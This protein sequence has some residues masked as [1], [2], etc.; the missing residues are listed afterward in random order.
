MPSQAKAF[1]SQGLS[2]QVA[3]DKESSCF[4]CLVC[5]GF[6]SHSRGVFAFQFTW[7]RLI[8][9]VKRTVS[10]TWRGDQQ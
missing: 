10:V 4:G 1:F 3:V 6:G 8:G 5:S 9:F 2:E 7:I